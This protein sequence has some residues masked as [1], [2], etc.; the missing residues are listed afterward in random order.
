MKEAG[1]GIELGSN[2]K[3]TTCT[4][5]IHEFNQTNYTSYSRNEKFSGILSSP[6]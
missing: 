1:S 3:L 4:T 5:H 6:N 2:K